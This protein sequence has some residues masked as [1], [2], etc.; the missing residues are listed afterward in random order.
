[1]CI[2]K[3]L[4]ILFYWGRNLAQSL[5]LQQMK[6]EK[7]VLGDLF[8]HVLYGCPSFAVVFHCFA[9]YLVRFLNLIRPFMSILPE[10]GKPD[11]KVWQDGCFV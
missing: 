7:I 8:N 11:R 6:K 4:S 5:K 9:F 2:N 1:M 10:I 3:R